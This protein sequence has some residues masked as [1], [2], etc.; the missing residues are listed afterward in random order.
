[1]DNLEFR[2]FLIVYGISYEEYQGMTKEKQQELVNRFKKEEK[3]RASEVKTDN[4]K[5]VGSGLQGL[6]CLIILIP[7]LLLFLYFIISMIF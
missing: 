1:M 7:I 3:E 5:K 2:K 6:G 4:L